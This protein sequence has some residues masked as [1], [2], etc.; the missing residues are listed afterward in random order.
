MLLFL[1]D[2]YASVT[3]PL[4]QLK[5]FARVSLEAGQS[6][7]VCF[8]LPP[9]AFTL[10]DRDLKRVAEPGEFRLYVGLDGPEKSVWLKA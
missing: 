6:A 5:A 7:S 3:R 2:V 4:R 9:A 10:L 1:R 8:V